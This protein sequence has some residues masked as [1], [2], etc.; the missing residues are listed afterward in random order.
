MDM[1]LTRAIQLLPIDGAKII[2]HDPLDLEAG[3]IGEAIVNRGVV[4]EDFSDAGNPVAEAVAASR[5]YGTVLFARQSYTMSAPVATSRTVLEGGGTR[6]SGPYVPAGLTD[7]SAVAKAG[8]WRSMLADDA[9]DVTLGSANEHVEHLGMVVPVT[10]SAA[11]YQKNAKYITVLH[12]DPSSYSFDGDGE[13]AAIPV[14]TR[15]VVGD[16]VQVQI[17]PGNM[18]GRIFGRDTIVTYSAGGDGA[19]CGAEYKIVNN[20][21]A[22]PFFGTATSKHGVNFFS[23]GLYDITSGFYFDEAEA[24]TGSRWNRILF[25][26]RKALRTALI[27]LRE[28]IAESSKLWFNISADGEVLAQSY[29]IAKRTA[30][31]VSSPPTGYER[32]FIDV[33]TN[34]LRRKTS[35]GGYT[36]DAQIL[37][38]ERFN[39]G[40]NFNC[41]ASTTAVV[42]DRST[43]GVAF[44]GL[45]TS[46]EA[47][48]IITVKDGK[49]DA[50][51]N[52]ISVVGTIDGAANY[53]IATNYGKASFLYDGTKWLVIG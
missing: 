2:P 36:I 3:T 1:T 25:V 20:S 46:P 39:T 4:V 49:G 10:N 50:A 41:T 26:A 5:P 35:T 16:D 19:G 17:M 31:D 42:V 30:A 37:S 40:S 38:V 44:I 22:Q 9:G 33:A 24:G 29:D 6:F 7:L 34:R 52:V 13:N 27:T 48:R 23:A 14:V 12:H 11:G 51:A 21:S 47:G 18:H 8:R 32:A 45:P 53:N 43:T 28:N 15:D